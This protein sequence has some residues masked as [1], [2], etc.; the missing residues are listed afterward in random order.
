MAGKIK[1][2]TIEFRGDTT[3]LD[4]ALNK[5]TKE[6][7]KI[8]Q[9]LKAVNRSLKFNPGNVDLLRQKQELLRA[10]ISET[11]DKLKLLK[12]QQEEMDASGVDKNSEEYR[13]L[14]REIIKTESQLKS[15]T[16]EERKL[17]AQIS[18]LGQFSAKMKEVGTSLEN[19]GQKMKGVSTAGAA[20][21]AT[22]GLI[23]GKSAKAADELNTMSKVY[24]ISTGEL[25]KYKAAADLADV[26]VEAIAKTH[27]KLEKTM[28][29]AANGSKSQKEA[30]DA[31]GVSVTDADGNLR[32]SE[33]VWQDV[34]GKLGEMTNE[35]ERNALAQKL[36]GKSAAELNPIILDGGETY[37]RTAEMFEQYGLDVIDQETL[38]RANAFNDSIDSIK[39]MSLTAI[40]TIG[41][42]LAAYLAPMLEKIVD[43]VG[44]IAG[45]L[46]NLDPQILAVIGVVASLVAALAPALIIAG[47]LAFAI[48]SISG[49]MATLGVSLGAMSATILPVIAVVAAL[50][51]IGV[52]LYKNWDKIKAKAAEI[53]N[54][55]STTFNSMKAKITS[56]FN[57]IV[58]TVRTK[59]NAVKDAI[60][61]PI[62]TAIDF[63]R[64]GIQ[65][66]KDIIGK[67]K[68]ELPHFDLP[69]FKIKGG[70]LPWGIGGKGTPPEI[71]VQWYDKGG[72]FRSPSVIGVGERRPEFVGAL[73]DLRK[74][75]REESG[76]SIVINVY[77]SDHMNVREL[78]AEVEKRLTAA[79]N[80]RRLAWQ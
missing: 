66:I 6:T 51:A 70:K 60:V 7:K 46:A 49:L 37:K 45:W 8:D 54:K 29:A 53:A 43:V 16:A 67:V 71:S 9:E 13:K 41:A 21:V 22:L 34:I 52:L 3:K 18:P 55:V 24:G 58:S 80:R 11:T 50:I 4:S 62:K 59:F 33:D 28:Y 75:I 32:D 38:D 69:H 25:Q 20:V 36:L 61:N 65:K 63:V 44:R 5:V 1:G 48:S 76:G 31:L 56:I 39:T 17:A 42:Q 72:I 40:Q 14:Q 12:R 27:Q 23:T 35:T 77:G 68:F 15:L 73:D 64:T 74:L 26:S 30:F 47:K 78:A 2:I 19:A 10:K 79:Q 57:T